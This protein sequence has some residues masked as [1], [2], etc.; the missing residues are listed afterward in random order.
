MHARHPSD[1]LRASQDHAPAAENV[2]DEIQQ[3]EQPMHIFAISN[4]HNLQ[5]G[6]RVRN[7]QLRN[8]TQ[9]SHER[10]LERKTSGPPNRECHA[11]FVRVRS[12]EDAFV[13]PHPN[14][15]YI[16]SAELDKE[17]VFPGKQTYQLENTAEAVSPVPTERL[18]TM[19]ISD[20]S[21][22]SAR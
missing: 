22:S 13:D 4:L 19:N 20:S 17:P 3:Y 21:L 15:P 9:H 5:R 6:M 14:V 7:P 12:C 11:P 2:I 8:N 18:A 1:Q 16:S 10:D